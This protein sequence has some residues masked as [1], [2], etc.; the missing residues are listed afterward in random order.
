MTIEPK[1]NINDFLEVKIEAGSPSRFHFME[2]M[3]VITQTCYGGTQIFYLC[4]SA[5]AEKSMSR[6]PAKE[7]GKPSNLKE[8]WM[9]GSVNRDQKDC[10]YKRY[11]EDE[12]NILAPHKLKIIQKAKQSDVL[13]MD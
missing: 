11:R 10:G 9:V 12:V 13:P 3:E 7:K 1:Y 5:L 4:R 6:E 8:F 2:V